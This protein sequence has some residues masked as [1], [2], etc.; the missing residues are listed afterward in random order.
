MC[1]V[2]ELSWMK[3]LGEHNQIHNQ[4][5]NLSHKKEHWSNVRVKI[6]VKLVTLR[7]SVIIGYLHIAIVRILYGKL[8]SLCDKDSVLKLFSTRTVFGF[9]Y[10]DCCQWNLTLDMSTWSLVSNFFFS[11]LNRSCTKTSLI[12]KITDYESKHC[13]SMQCRSLL[14]S[15]VDRFGLRKCERCK[16]LF[17]HGEKPL[18]VLKTYSSKDLK[19]ILRNCNLR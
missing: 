17:K 3:N 16:T 1:T 9:L 8:W 11:S 15:L 12:N 4:K 14:V 13:C 5:E 19:A 18:V 6:F 10:C 2:Y 7:R